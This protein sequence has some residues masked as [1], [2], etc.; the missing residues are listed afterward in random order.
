MLQSSNRTP[1]YMNRIISVPKKKEML[2]ETRVQKINGGEMTFVWA[3]HYHLNHPP[4]MVHTHTLH[5]HTQTH[6]RACTHRYKRI[7]THAYAHM[8]A[9]A[10]T[11]VHTHTHTHTHT[12]THAHISPRKKHSIIWGV[13]GGSRDDETA[14]CAVWDT[15]LLIRSPAPPTPPTVPPP[16]HYHHLLFLSSCLS[17]IF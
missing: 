13:R 16:H 2:P 15:M 9:H 1:S 6:E 5:A 8:Y 17:S 4:V 10:H 14:S 7:H 3:Q 12:R 11:Y